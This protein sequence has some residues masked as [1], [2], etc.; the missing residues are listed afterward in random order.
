MMLLSKET[1]CDRLRQIQNRLA[2]P[3]AYCLLFLY[4][5][6]CRVRCNEKQGTCTLHISDEFSNTV[7]RLKIYKHTGISE[8]FHD[9]RSR[10]GLTCDSKIRIF[11]EAAPTDIQ[12]CTSSYNTGKVLACT[13]HDVAAKS[14]VVSRRRTSFCIPPIA[15]SRG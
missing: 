10:H 9:S 14:R 15:H 5:R 2:L 11:A 7:F 4:Q 8:I 12:L 1:C 6:W 13:A 3:T